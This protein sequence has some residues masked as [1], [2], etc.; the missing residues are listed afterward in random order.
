M[1]APTCLTCSGRGLRALPAAIASTPPPTPPAALIP[2]Q[3][4]SGTCRLQP[5]RGHTSGSSPG[6]SPKI[7]TKEIKADVE[8]KEEEENAFFVVVDRPEDRS[9]DA[10]EE[11]ERIN[12]KKT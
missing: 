3:P 7:R 9:D 6:S 2:E 12:M 10:S 5:S 1:Y 11:S 8:E 4:E